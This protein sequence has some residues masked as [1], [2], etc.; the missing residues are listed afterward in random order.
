MRT[1]HNASIG[2]VL[3]LLLSIVLVACGSSDGR[4]AAVANSSGLP[5]SSTLA[6]LT[7]AEDWVLCDWVNAKEGGYGR[8][9]S[10]SDGS[11]QMSDPDQASCADSVVY[12][13]TKCPSLS[14]GDVEDCANSTGANLCSV[15]TSA[16]C[17]AFT[18]CIG[19]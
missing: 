2:P 10:C 17:A 18:A 14:V 13:G 1:D 6:S 3:P 16:A 12:L 9:V 19:P 4:N 5:R 11:Q 15:P 8:T 7:T